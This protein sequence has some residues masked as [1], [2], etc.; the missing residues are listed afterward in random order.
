M[1][2][3]GGFI[4]DYLEIFSVICYNMQNYIDIMNNPVF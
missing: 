4:S 2:N 1:L 3:F